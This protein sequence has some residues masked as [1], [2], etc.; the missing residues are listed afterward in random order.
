[1]S[2]VKLP[3]PSVRER[4]LDAAL[5]T[6]RRE[7]LTGFT[8]TAVA[9]RARVRQSHLTYYFPTR[10][11]LL[12]ATVLRFAELAGAGLGGRTGDAAL[13]HLAALVTERGHMRMFLGLVVEAADDPGLR[14]IVVKGTEQLERALATAL[15]GEHTT[16]RA[17]VALAT[18]WGLGLYRFAVR[19]PP[20]RD[21]VLPAL[22]RLGTGPDGR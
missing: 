4:L 8:Q 20:E 22:A 3:R 21:P 19:P 7:G 11:D 5:A 13:T 2:L 18:V 9:R 14:A 1:M 6:L 16:E 10:R 15:G 17:R 12:E